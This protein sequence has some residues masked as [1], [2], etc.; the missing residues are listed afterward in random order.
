MKKS[1]KKS[2]KDKKSKKVHQGSMFEGQIIA[3][4]VSNRRRKATFKADAVKVFKAAVKPYFQLELLQS[5]EYA[6]MGFF[7]FK[8]CK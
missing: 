6:R 5:R 1:K 2:K 8:V 7:I 4:T 3:L